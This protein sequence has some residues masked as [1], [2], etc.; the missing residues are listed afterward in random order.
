MVN[1]TEKI[2]EYGVLKFLCG[3]RTDAPQDRDGDG[4]D[5]EYAWRSKKD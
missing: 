1:I 3:E 5:A 4:E 2:K